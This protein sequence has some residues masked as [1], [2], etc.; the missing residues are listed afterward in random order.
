GEQ[1]VLYLVP[2]AGAGREVAHANRK[3]E[4]VRYALKLLLPDVR[5][6][7]VASTCICSDE[8]LPSVG[9][10][11]RANL[12]PPGFDGRHR[13]HWCV[14]VDTHTHETVVGAEVVDA[15]WNR[16]TNRST[17]KI[18]NIDQFWFT[19]RLPLTAAILEVANQLFLLRIDGDHRNAPLDAALCLGVD[20]FELCVAVHMLS[21]FNGLVW[22]LEAVAML[23]EQFGHSLVAGLDALRS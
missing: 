20:V 17:R 21:A 23:A 18:M 15:I 19:L 9:V 5:T 6:I 12:L 2:L 16:L 8:D 3:V 7:A 1:T 4:L 14:V 22:R 13:K 10:A 11:L